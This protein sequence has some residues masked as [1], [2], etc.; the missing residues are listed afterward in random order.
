MQMQVSSS[1]ASGVIVI[2][3][4]MVIFDITAFVSMGEGKTV[5]QH[6]DNPHK[7]YIMQTNHMITPLANAYAMS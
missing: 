4:W 2:C 5:Y 1:P 7:L 6:I 3:G